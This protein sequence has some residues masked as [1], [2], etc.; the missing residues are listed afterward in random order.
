M[1][2]MLLAL[3]F[4]ECQ[5]RG[6][7][8]D[9]IAGQEMDADFLCIPS[10]AESV[11]FVRVGRPFVTYAAPMRGIVATIGGS[12]ARGKTV[13]LELPRNSCGTG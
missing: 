13:S 3:S 1:N 7:W 5:R 6:I 2:Q 4:E 10:Q 12:N 9:E 8:S 11:R